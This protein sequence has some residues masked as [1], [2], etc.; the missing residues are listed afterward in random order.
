M[1][2]AAKRVL[3]IG[4]YMID[5]YLYGQTTRISPE[6][7]VP[8]VKVTEEKN[9]LGGA[10]NVANNLASLGAQV[11]SCGVIGADKD[12]NQL[13]KLLE[14]KKIDTSLM[15]EDSERPTTVKKRV[16]SGNNYQLLRLD[17]EMSGDIDKKLEDRVIKSIIKTLPG[18]DA[19]VFSDYAKGMITERVA[20]EIVAACRRYNK[21]TIADTKPTR[22]SFYKGCYLITPNLKEACEMSGISDDILKMGERLVKQLDC[23]VFI[24]RG[25]EGISVFEKNG[26]HTHVPPISITKVFDVTGAGDTVVAVSALGVISGLDLVSAARLAN[27]AAG[28]VVQKPGTSIVTPD[29]LL[30]VFRNEIS[31][32]LKESIEVKQKV[33]EQQIEKIEKAAKL[34]IG[35]Y[36][37]KN[38]IIAFGNGGSA[39]D[40]Q[41]LVGELVGRF[42]IERKGLAAIALTT[43]S[44]VVTAIAND[45]GYDMVFERQIEANASR[46]DVVV[47]ISTSGNSKNVINAIAKAKALGCKTIA[48]LG[49]DGGKIAGMCDVD[50]VV[51]SDN[52]P[53]IQEAHI[54]IIHIICELLDKDLSLTKEKKP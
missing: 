9:V 26:V 45:Y 47:G 4:D 37:N 3:V 18:L 17:Y 15:I 54:A 32:Y 53:R 10:G 44:S 27:F 30:S 21:P 36:K 24:T 41:H 7:P 11:L 8:I 20:K 6:A 14:N 39:S 2:F 5:R 31:H 33:I 42:K 51:P 16:I 28:L 43:D 50:I 22:A 12:G 23:R 46:G 49:K 13:K 38:K 40:A 35:A 29:E 1:G 52:T 34:F 19:V 25:S 48:L